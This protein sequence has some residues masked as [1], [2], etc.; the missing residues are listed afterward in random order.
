MAEMP[1]GVQGSVN[2]DLGTSGLSDNTTPST[3]NMTTGEAL[4]ASSTTGETLAGIER[5]SLE[6]VME[7]IEQTPVLDPSLLPH[8]SDLATERTGLVNRM[9]QLEADR[10]QLL[11]DFNSGNFVSTQYSNHTLEGLNDYIAD[12]NALAGAVG[13][14][15]GLVDA[16][17]TITHMQALP[18][19]VAGTAILGVTAIQGA[20][21]AYTYALSNPV[22]VTTFADDFLSTL[23]V[24]GSPSP[25]AIG[26]GTGIGAAGAKF[27]ADKLR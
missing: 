26:Y 8:D 27:I 4:A 20:Q 6:S 5:P 9:E 7:T 13:T 22:G 18:F 25:S 3:D 10:Q 21:S 12:Y 16:G 2:S 19:Q 17:T 23:L 24:P 1:S 15:N 11:E 14:Y